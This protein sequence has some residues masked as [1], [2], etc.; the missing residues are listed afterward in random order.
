MPGRRHFDD[1]WPSPQSRPAWPS[2]IARA[3]NRLRRSFGVVARKRPLQAGTPDTAPP[4][5]VEQV[6]ARVR[7]MEE[8]ACVALL[9]R[10]RRGVQPTPAG[11]TLLH[12]ARL[13]MQQVERMRGEVGEH[14]RGL[15]GHVRLLANTAAM[16]DLPEALAAFLADHPNVDIDLDERPS[17]DVARAVAEGLADMGMAA[18]HAGL[19]GV[20]RYRFRMLEDP[21]AE[22][23][24]LVE[25]LS[26]PP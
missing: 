1:G 21:W 25:R 11:W 2:A 9:D 13:V 17:T 23:R 6:R 14:A 19:T 12:H 20:E 7:G 15:K 22:R 26:M 4:K 10:G 24:L 8:Q 16:A 3:A 5:V 18:D